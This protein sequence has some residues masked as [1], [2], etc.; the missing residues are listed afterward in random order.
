[1]GVNTKPKEIFFV[2]IETMPEFSRYR[3]PTCDE[4]DVMEDD[5][6]TIFLYNDIFMKTAIKDKL[7]ERDPS[8]RE[9]FKNFD[10]Y[11][12]S[13]ERIS[14]EEQA[15]R[16]N[17]T[18]HRLLKEANVQDILFTRIPKQPWNVTIKQREEHVK[19]V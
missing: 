11:F 16:A 18:V 9:T 8:L 12:Q 3:Q 4:E 14:E 2:F 13:L 17:E 15:F 6:Q 7:L 1:L 5:H 10:E 19:F